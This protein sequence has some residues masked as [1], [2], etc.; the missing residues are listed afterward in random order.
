MH[1][2]H[3]GFKDRAAL[4][5]ERGR[6]RRHAQPS[7]R[8]DGATALSASYTQAWRHRGIR[9]AAEQAA[10]FSSALPATRH[11]RPGHFATLGGW[12]APQRS[13]TPRNTTGHHFLCQT[14]R[15]S[16]WLQGE[17]STRSATC[18]PCHHVRP[19][20]IKGAC[21]SITCTFCFE[22]VRVLPA[23]RALS[24]AYTKPSLPVCDANKGEPKQ[25]GGKRKQ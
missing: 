4:V 8:A 18:R 1:V 25:Y 13:T 19:W 22:V 23:I 3:W 14:Q 16:F 17:A 7:H 11:T 21:S 10:A 15:I 5:G 9:S 2:S 24:A 6:G 20:T 12:P